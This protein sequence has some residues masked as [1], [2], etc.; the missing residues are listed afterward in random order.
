MNPPDHLIF[1]IAFASDRFAKAYNPTPSQLVTLIFRS[2]WQWGS[3]P[4]PQQARIRVNTEL[5]V[6]E[7]T[8][9]RLGD[10]IYRLRKALINS[11]INSGCS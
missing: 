9:K 5:R 6:G 3:Y 8:Q 7:V 2:A 11:Q 1:G 10:F 4:N